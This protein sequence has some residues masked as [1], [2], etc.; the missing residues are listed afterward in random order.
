MRFARLAWFRFGFAIRG[1]ELLERQFQLSQL[2]AQFF[3]GMAELHPPQPGDLKLQF[4][5][6]QRSIGKLGLSL[7]QRRFRRHPRG[8]LSFH[9]G[10]LRFD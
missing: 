4:L 3:R 9:V 8:A 1:F 7:C 2:G 6:Q 5:D 10:S